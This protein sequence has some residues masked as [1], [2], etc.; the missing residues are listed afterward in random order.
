MVSVAVQKPP[1]LKIGEGGFLTAKVT[2]MDNEAVHAIFLCFLE[3]YQIAILEI[4][5]LNAGLIK[6]GMFLSLPNDL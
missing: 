2:T 3:A 4:A 5:F 1:V 6:D